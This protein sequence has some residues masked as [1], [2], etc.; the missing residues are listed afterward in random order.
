ML[1]IRN[2]V[3]AIAERVQAHEISPGNYARFLWQNSINSRQMG[4]NSYG[5]AD[6]ANILY[7]LGQL[8]GDPVLRHAHVTTLQG[9]QDPKT[10]HFPEP[11]HHDIHTTAHCVAALELFDAKPLHPLHELLPYRDIQTFFDWMEREDWLHLGRMAHVGAGL[12]AALVLTEAVDL[13]WVKDYFDWFD[14]HCDPDS[15]L[16]RKLPADKF[17]LYMQV[18]DAFH[19][20]FNYAHFRKPFP[21]P[22]ALIDTCLEM[23]HNGTLPEN[24]AKQF[25]F[26]EMDWAYCLNRASRQTPHRF[27][28]VKEVLRQL[29]ETMVAFLS[30]VDWE[31]NDGA[32]DLH[33]LF[34]TTCCLAE[35]QQALPG[36]ILSEKPLRLVLDRRPFI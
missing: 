16:W 24:F 6:A 4:T 1:D 5:C 23:P 12:F 17:P 22:E 28:E 20:L 19:Y 9:L 36:E 27:Y 31:T 34:G 2:T 30:N 15:G 10:G 32:N 25:H 35:L 8:P 18:G 11:T 3:N 13:R 29:A 14:R 26:I 33:L 7:T 21:H